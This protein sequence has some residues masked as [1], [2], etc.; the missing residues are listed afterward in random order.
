MK[1]TA[2]PGQELRHRREEMGHSVYEAFRHTRVP[3]AYIE[4]LEQGDLSAL[5]GACY[6][7]GF[8]KSYCEF[9]GL[10]AERYIDVF[11]ASS[12]PAPARFLRRTANRASLRAPLWLDDLLTWVVVMG[13]VLLGWVTY[14]VVFSPHSDVVESGVE[15]STLDISQPPSPPDKL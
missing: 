1:Q 9:L 13:V 2:F 15:A 3:V 5:P 14:S 7:V 11:R 8:L 12:R 10:E 4:A 6:T